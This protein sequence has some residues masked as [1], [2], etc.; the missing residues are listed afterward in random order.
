MEFEQDHNM[1]PSGMGEAS[2][3]DK[4]GSD[5]D[6]DNNKKEE[7][8][9]FVPDDDDDDEDQEDAE[10][11][12]EDDDDDEE[13]DSDEDYGG[14]KKRKKR[15]PPPK[16]GGRKGKITNDDINEFSELLGFDP[17]RRSERKRKEPERV[18]SDDYNYGVFGAP[19]NALGNSDVSEGD[20]DYGDDAPKPKRRKPLPPK[21]KA[22]K[23]DDDD[24]FDGGDYY[25]YRRPSRGK[26]GKSMS[27]KES[28]DEEEE[29]V[30]ED[31]MYEVNVVE[32]APEE[33]GDVIE[34]IVDHRDVKIEGEEGIITQYRVKWQ[35]RAYIHTTWEEPSA[36]VSV[37]GYKKLQNYIKLI[38]ETKNWSSSVTA[39]ERESANIAME[40]RREMLADFVHVDR[41][42][43]VRDSADE[44][45]DI[46]TQ[47]YLVKW[48]NLPYEECTWENPDDI[49]D[50]Q[51]EIDAYLARSQNSLI[52]N[53]NIAPKNRPKFTKMTTQPR[54]W[55]TGDLRD[56]QLEGLNWLAYNW[57]TNTNGI[58]ADE[59][60]LGKTIQ[61]ISILG[62]L[63]YEMKISGPFLVVVPLS[64]VSNW[65]NEFKKWAPGINFVVYTGNSASRQQI[66]D[67]EFYV[68]RNGRGKNPRIKF[69]VLLTT[70]EIIIK[71]KNI[72]GGV[73]WNYLAVDEGHRLKNTESIL[74]E[75]L[76]DFHTSNRLLLT[77]TP[78]QNSI[79]ELWSLLHFLT[80]QKFTSLAEFEEEYS[81]IK[82]EE[83]I[84]K[85]HQE[86]K[87]H[88]LRRVK[89]DVE[90]SL[91]AKIERILRVEMS[92]QQQKYYKWILSRN[93]RELNKGVKGQA[94]STLLNIVMELKK[95]ANHPYLFENAED[96]NNPD[97][98]RAMIYNSGKMILLDKLLLR[99]RETGHRVLIFSQMVRML[100]ILSD[101]L[102]ARGFHYQ[103]LDGSMGH[104]LRKKAMEHFNAKGSSD[105]CFLLS[106]RAGGLG[107]NLS[108]ADTVIIFDSDWNPQNDLQA[109]ARAHRIGQTKVVNIY[110][111]VTK[112][113]VEESIL[114]RAKDKMVLDHLIIQTMGENN[115][116]SN[117]K[118]QSTA[119][120]KDDLAAILRFGAKELFKEEEEGGNTEKKDS[121]QPSEMDIDEILARAETAEEQE[122]T[123]AGAELL[124]AF[125]VADFSGVPLS[126]AEENDP[127]FWKRVIP[128]N[129]VEESRREEQALLYLPPRTKRAVQSYSEEQ[130]VGLGSEDTKR[131]K[132]RK[133][134]ETKTKVKKSKEEAKTDKK[135]KEKKENGAKKATTRK[136]EKPS[137]LRVDPQKKETIKTENIMKKKGTSDFSES[138]IRAFVF[139]LK[140]FGQLSRL[141]EI[142]NDAKVSKKGTKLVETLGNEIVDLCSKALKAGD[143][144][145]RVLV[146]YDNVRI[147]ATDLMQRMDDLA[148]LA[149]KVSAYS[150]HPENFRIS[151]PVRAFGTFDWG[152]KD[153]A[154]LLFG[155]YKY[156]FGSWDEI[157]QDKVLGLTKKIAIGST[158]E[159]V[160]P[161][162]DD[163]KRRAETLLKALSSERAKSTNRGNEVKKSPSKEAKSPKPKEPRPVKEPK[164]VDRKEKTERKEPKE[165][166]V[167]SRPAKKEDIYSSSKCKTHL[168]DVLVYLG[169]FKDMQSDDNMD[170]ADKIKNTK[171]YLLAIGDAI[172]AV[173][174]R[175]KSADPEKLEKNL[176]KYA[177]NYTTQEGDQLRQLYT[178]IA[179][180]KAKQ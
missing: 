162:K 1:Q 62:W 124:N 179:A 163:L 104:D 74:Y 51:S 50:Y 60:G 175:E 75:V 71:D 101:Y 94:Q 29:E 9:D 45:G 25:D 158:S 63:L 61:T 100:D 102:T 6:E 169:K 88:I 174:R 113:T 126:K 153:D 127:E 85:L 160:L 7:E 87:P 141:D 90:K 46:V 106:T 57:C 53:P 14:S 122:H 98:L 147:D 109:E 137:E 39:E 135:P 128:Q 5:N 108:T 78:L 131:K 30:D 15:P 67:Y 22:T 43:A 96:A 138:E 112:S 52:Y 28:S 136:K 2:E 12:E 134:K 178:K 125:K 93:F 18:P 77:G 26:G 121:E 161:R 133:E 70:Y 151:I 120:N 177:S 35:G 73:R 64:T 107:I 65:E 33:E 146:E 27:Y 24:D 142:M 11:E 79:K 166:K 34:K 54:G 155:V 55:I 97:V 89:K 116:E 105:F 103:R 44:D 49:K 4:L 152:P 157:Q 37:K 132:A 36:L 66:Q 58:L 154:M 80:P 173:L 48:K 86:L 145:G 3:D 156:G 16:F 115:R 13:E 81:D 165:A 170:K 84:A 118:S 123:G 117:T 129:V 111:F 42:I 110:R 8:D 159:N 69:D 172:Q 140:K 176:W 47:Q 56:Y 76:K 164:K 32:T 38:E 150:K 148:Y 59:M 168:K 10:E 149:K 95:V 180:A 130:A 21:K 23:Y 171:E 20:S 17:R 119:F 40:M 167:D 41:I 72:L 139:S 82:E 114:Q 31:E 143:D 92:P 68:D 19:P 144:S 91:P 83:Q 99:L